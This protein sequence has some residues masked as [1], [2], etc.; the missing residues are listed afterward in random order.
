MAKY[1]LLFVGGRV[2]DERRE[3]NEDDWM[4]WMAKLAEAGVLVDGAAF[5][6]GKVL[7]PV[8]GVRPFVWEK[9]SKAAGYCVVRVENLDEA[10][11]LAKDCPHLLP[12]YGRGSVEVREITEEKSA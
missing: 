7:N 8:E 3:Q 1:A 10:V 12:E 9:S 2:P 6:G 4:A 5:G 11:K